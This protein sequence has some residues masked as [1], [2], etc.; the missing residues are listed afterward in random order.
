MS[1]PNA[2][3]L[4]RARGPNLAIPA[5]Q[6]RGT[7]HAAPTT[8]HQPRG[9]NHSKAPKSGNV[10]LLLDVNGRKTVSIERRVL[11]SITI[12]T[13]AQSQAS[14]DKRKRISKMG[15]K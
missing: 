1:A 2:F 8:R 15:T 11:G 4:V 3:T 6:P 14:V 10:H 5:G 7:N 12:E 9:T 13:R